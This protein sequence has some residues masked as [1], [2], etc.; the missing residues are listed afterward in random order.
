MRSL[1]FLAAVL[2]GCAA[3]AEGSSPE[4]TPKAL[5][6]SPAPVGFA[7]VFTPTEAARDLTEAAVS[8]WAAA[9]GL[10]IT[11]GPN[12]IPVD[13]VEHI[14][15]PATGDEKCGATSYHRDANGVADAVNYV[16][17][18]TSAANRCLLPQQSLL[19]E[20]AHSLAPKAPNNGHTEAGLMRSRQDP[21]AKSIDAAALEVVCNELPCLTFA[22]EVL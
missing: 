17:I 11:V 2:I 12:G 20:M 22:P 9:T 21:A 4:L 16:Q 7:A 14:F 15:D 5:S 18:S 6:A 19:H 3:S 1:L 10:N 13:L 8:R